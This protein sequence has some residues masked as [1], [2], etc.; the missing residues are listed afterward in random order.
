MKPVERFRLPRQL[1]L[2]EPPRRLPVWSD[3]PKETRRRVTEQLARLLE[4]YIRAHVA[5]K[6][7]RECRE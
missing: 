1:D 7:R 5:E 6:E 4:G 3:L 2:F